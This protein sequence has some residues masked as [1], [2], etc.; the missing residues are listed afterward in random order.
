V[1]L[2]GEPGAGKAAAARAIH[3]A[4]PRAARPF[5]SIDCEALA[6]SEIDSAL[7]GAAGAARGGRLAEAE[8]GTLLT[9]NVGAAPPSLQVRLVRLLQ[10]HEAEPAGGGGPRKVD[11][12]LIATTRDDLGVAVRDGRFRGDLLVRLGVVRIVMPPL[13]E[14]REDLP[15]LVAGFVRAANAAHHRRVTG[16]TPGAL[17]RLSEHDWPGNVGEL[18]SV[19]EAMVALVPGRRALEVADLPHDLRH[20][21]GS[22]EPDVAVGMTV[23]EAERRLIEATLRHTNRDKRRAAA[24]LGIGLRTLYRK[25]DG[26]R[27]RTRP[28]AAPKL[29]RRPRR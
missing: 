22:P 15:L 14:R 27:R 7:F 25:L 29:R 26:P 12:R 2:E 13:R 28:A 17:D 21:G 3:D 16:V 11:V 8:G 1:L 20:A 23:A 10:D 19:I 18:E 6:P 5:V 9:E 24:L 4:S